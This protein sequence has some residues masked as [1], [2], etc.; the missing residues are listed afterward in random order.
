MKVFQQHRIIIITTLTLVCIHCYPSYGWIIQL[1]KV[2]K[3]NCIGNI[4]NYN[5]R[6]THQ[7]TIIIRHVESNK[8]DDNEDRLFTTNIDDN[9]D[10]DTIPLDMSELRNAMN[11]M[12]S[13]NRNRNNNMK[14]NSFTNNNMYTLSEL[15]QYASS[16]VT[17]NYNNNRSNTEQEQEQE[18][19]KIPSSS[20]VAE[21][22][23]NDDDDD[24]DGTLL[25]PDTYLRMSDSTEQDKDG[26]MQYL[27]QGSLTSSLPDYMNSKYRESIQNIAFDSLPLNTNG[28][29]SYVNS[30]K[31]DKLMETM[32]ILW[33]RFYTLGSM[34]NATYKSSE[35]THQKIFEEE[36]GYFQQSDIFRKSL[37]DDT[38]I[39]DAMTERRSKRFKKRQNEFIE[40]L[41]QQ[42]YDLE[43]SLLKNH[44]KEVNNETCTID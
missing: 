1:N 41:D 6:R 33:D 37:L 16:I 3:M 18:K 28:T 14:R 2:S 17:S 34:K 35:D 43:L 38:K 32:S 40:S 24:D 9:D 30:T 7:S 23:D 5:N 10:N 26:M 44:T 36:L 12:Y 15:E 25:D 20:F 31:D 27:G 21:I 42:I 13:V 19:F 29:I 4:N 8:D 39:V 11:S 22:T